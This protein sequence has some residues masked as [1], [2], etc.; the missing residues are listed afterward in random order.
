MND[1]LKLKFAAWIAPRNMLAAGD[2]DVQ[3]MKL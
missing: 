1:S 3:N 2:D